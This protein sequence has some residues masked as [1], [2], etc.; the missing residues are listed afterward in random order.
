MSS[1]RPFVVAGVFVSVLGV[2]LLAKPPAREQWDERPDEED[3]REAYEHGEMGRTPVYTA[4]LPAGN[5]ERVDGVSGAAPPS[6]ADEPWST[7][8]HDPQ[9]TFAAAGCVP[10]ELKTAWRHV[11]APTTSTRQT[12]HAV[13]TRDSVYLAFLA[14]HPS[15][16][17]ATA[18]AIARLDVDGTQRWNRVRGRDAT[19]GHWL[20][21]VPSI[22]AILQ[23]DDGH[24]L[25]SMEDGDLYTENGAQQADCDWW[26]QTIVN[27][28]RMIILNEHSDDCPPMGLFAFDLD[29]NL[30]WSTNVHGGGPANKGA[31]TDRA[32]GIA[33]DDGVVF[34][35]PRY[36]WYDETN[37]IPSGVYAFD[38]TD[39]SKLWFVDTQPMSA[40]SASDGRVYVVEGDH[41]TARSQSDGAVIW[42]ANVAGAGRPA[43]AVGHGIVVVAT[44]AG[45]EGFA[46]DTG[47]KQ[48]TVDVPGAVTP[49][50]FVRAQ[51]A[52][53]GYL[54]WAMKNQGKYIPSTTIAIALGSDTVIV[55]GSEKLVVLSLTDGS[56][57]W[58][59]VPELSDGR[60]REPVIVGSRV[61]VT[62]SPTNM[63]AAGLLALDA[64][65]DESCDPGD[66]G[67]GGTNDDSGDEGGGD[68]GGDS[69]DD[70]D[71][72]DG[73][74][75]DTSSGGD[76]GD[77]GSGA[78]SDD[79]NMDADG[80]AGGCGCAAVQSGP[81]GALGGLLLA[82]VLVRRRPPFPR[83]SVDNRTDHMA[84]L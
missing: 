14:E 3:E 45:V 66:G 59:G 29:F 36:E 70:G 67:D 7:Y 72:D 18:Q 54:A 69:G 61:Y 9:R 81:P 38:E 49:E 35:G 2:V 23:N 44:G 21:L 65:P 84:W 57:K 15:A 32:Q 75:A 73:D 37:A 6:T 56:E 27:G 62:D 17:W 16:S 64:E 33:L 82:L 83:R 50:M 71:D 42:T 41:L 55:T 47:E 12:S 78:E 80:D 77:D 5:T 46:A 53:G 11:P 19:F 43:P 8:G 51:G 10:G 30:Q 34:Y 76:D 13:A 24:V 60:V 63:A 58:S 20:S 74:G 48:W 31:V 25:W 40:L 79:A 22:D 39:G 1:Y 28:D 26:G 4:T 52:F 68:D